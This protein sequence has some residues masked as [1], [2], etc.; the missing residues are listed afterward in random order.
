MLF[1]PGRESDSEA[2]DLEHAEKLRQVKAVLEEVTCLVSLEIMWFLEIIFF[3]FFLFLFSSIVISGLLFAHFYLWHFFPV[4]NWSYTTEF[5]MGPYS[6]S[7]NQ[8][9]AP[10]SI[11]GHGFN[12][13]RSLLQP[14]E[15]GELSLNFNPFFKEKQLFLVVTRVVFLW[16][17]GHVPFW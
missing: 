3:F 8:W 16:Y 12:L 15:S 6:Y 14:D 10:S 7:S 9:I 2:E 5:S 13:S 11:T 4:D 17:L 1:R